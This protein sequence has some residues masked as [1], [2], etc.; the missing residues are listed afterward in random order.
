MIANKTNKSIEKSFGEI[1]GCLGITPWFMVVS[2]Y[3]GRLE[4]LTSR[5]SLH[6][7]GSSSVVVR[8]SDNTQSNY[9]VFN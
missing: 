6:N 3:A 9:Y 2:H 5:D 4:A 7:S 8:L 1:G